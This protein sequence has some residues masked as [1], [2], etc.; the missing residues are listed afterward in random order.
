MSPRCGLALALAGS[1]L[2]S[3][4][5]REAG[6]G[7]VVVYSSVDDVFARPIAQRFQEETGIEVRLVPD[8][9]ET[10]STGLLNR[11]IAEK[12][13]P[14]ADVFWSGDPVRAAV[15]KRRGL[16]ASY[17]S[18]AATGLPPRF[19][20]PE[21]HWTGFSA[22]ARVLIYN[23]EKV[24]EEQAPDS[25]FDLVEPRFR[26]QACIANPLFGTTSM[27]AAALFAAL[28]EQ[29]ARQ[30]FEDFTANG[31]RIVSSNGEVRRR[32]AN[33]ECTVGI[34]D[35]DDANVAR[36]EGKPVGIVFP[37]A[38]GIGTLIIPNAAVLI[39]GAPHP[40]AGRR[41]IDFLLAPE[42]EKALAASEAAQM[43]VR[44]GLPPP[45][46]LPALAGLKA[47]EV[48]YGGLA[49]LLEELSRGF[50]KE[51]VDRNSG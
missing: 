39:A 16:S 8:T 13:R 40:E 26:G 30:L 14:Q 41:F 28:G 19:S 2:L 44:P 45:A 32:V 31:G 6:E 29:R 24:P 23:R 27:H 15:L 34:T 33:G 3:G 12:E 21:G 11:L 7:T 22:R 50:L 35:T 1:I 47:M 46:G 37:D 4:C 5:G 9:E 18:P 36:L 10:K 51:W 38:D 43:P 25:I 49:A 48:D 42:T 20:D 17:R